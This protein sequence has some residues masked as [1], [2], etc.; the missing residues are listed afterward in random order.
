MDPAVDLSEFVT[1]VGVQSF[2]MQLLVTPFPWY[3]VL[4]EQVKPPTVSVHAALTSQLL[5]PVEHS[6]TLTH[7]GVFHTPLVQVATPEAA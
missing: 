4:H 5:A 1:L 2:A 6:S 3:P 7:V